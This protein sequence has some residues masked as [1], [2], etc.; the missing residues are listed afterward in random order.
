MRSRTKTI[1]VFDGTGE[2]TLD[3][4][5]ATGWSIIQQKDNAGFAGTVVTLKQAVNYP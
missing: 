1:V 5:L 2:G 4:H 3:T